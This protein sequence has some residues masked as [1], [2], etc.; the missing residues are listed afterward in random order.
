MLLQETGPKDQFEYKALRLPLW[1]RAAEIAR[2]V[3]RG[4]AHWR[5]REAAPN[6]GSRGSAPETRGL[7]SSEN[8]VQNQKQSKNKKIHPSE[9]IPI[10]PS[11]WTSERILTVLRAT[12]SRE[13]HYRKLRKALERMEIR[14]SGFKKPNL[15]ARVR[16][17]PF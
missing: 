15:C 1:G 13:L 4:S 2:G 7:H 6:A 5:G 9:R 10:R 8:Q 17:A 3:P 16:T 12:I 14:P 11:G